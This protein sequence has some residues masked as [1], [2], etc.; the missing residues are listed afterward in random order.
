[1]M[2]ALFQRCQL[3]PSMAV[4]GQPAGQGIEPNWDPAAVEFACKAARAC[5][6]VRLNDPEGELPALLRLANAGV[7][8]AA[9]EAAYSKAE[10]AWRAFAARQ[11]YDDSAHSDHELKTTAARAALRAAREEHACAVHELQTAR[12]EL[13]AE[14][15][16]HAKL[17][18]AA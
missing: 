11:A 17:G 13:I 14:P 18:A 6:A 9:A 4:I 10:R 8:L 16:S 12:G 3:S 2:P 1:M 15:V 5:K 7:Q